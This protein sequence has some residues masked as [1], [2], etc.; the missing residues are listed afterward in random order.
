AALSLHAA[1]GIFRLMN[2]PCSAPDSSRP[3]TGFV[4]LVGAGP[5]DPGL[6]TVRAHDLLAQADAVVYDALVNPRIVQNGAV[7][8]D[9]EM[10]DVGKRGG[11]PSARQD[12]INA[13]LV[14]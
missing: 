11:A 3:T 2:A 5:G 9:A 1:P 12:A 10:H 8:A 14:R 13:L 4:S 6:L 7:R